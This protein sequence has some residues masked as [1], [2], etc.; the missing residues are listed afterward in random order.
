MPSPECMLEHWQDIVFAVG[1]IVFTIALVPAI[2]K[3]KY[4]PISTCILTGFMIGIYAATDLTLQL[5]LSAI[6]SV[7]SALLWIW[8]GVKQ[9]YER[10]D[11]E[12]TKLILKLDL[13]TYLTSLIGLASIHSIIVLIWPITIVV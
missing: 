12:D 11:Y 10:N 9:I 7:I 5:W 13:F 8:M 4:P 6:S 1:S 2:I 3:R